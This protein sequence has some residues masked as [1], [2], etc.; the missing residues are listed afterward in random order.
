LNELSP[1]NMSTSSA[2]LFR[3]IYDESTGNVVKDMSAIYGFLHKNKVPYLTAYNGRGDQQ[4]KTYLT[5]LY[6]QGFQVMP[7]F[8][9]ADEALEYQAEQYLVKPLVGGSGH[10]V[11]TLS[12]KELAETNIEQSFVIQP[13]MDIAYETSY[14]YID[15]VFQYALKTRASRWDLVVYEP[16]ADELAFGEKCVAWNPIKGVQRVDSL[17]TTDGKQYLLELEDWAPFLSLYDSENTP[18]DV[19][20]KNLVVSLRNFD[21]D[22]L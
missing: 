9:S 8:V 7:T 3:C 18:K 6:K 5:D 14:L 4:G 12:R 15:N 13:K 17:W 22:D 2:Y 11:R 16:S 1:E 21:Y 19:F 20:I 10:G